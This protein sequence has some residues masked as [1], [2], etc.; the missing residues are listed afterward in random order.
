MAAFR[1]F[2]PTALAFFK[3][4]SFHQDR[5]WFHQNKSL[6]EDEVKAPM[7]ALLEDLTERFEKE[8]IPLRGDKKSV[9]RINRDIRFSKDKRPY[10]TH[11][12]AVMTPSGAKGDPGLIYIHITADGLGSWN[13]A[14]EGSFLA[15]G[16]HLPDSTVLTAFRNAIRKNPEAFQAME[17]ELKKAKLKLETSN[18]LTRVPRGFEDMK[19][20]P[21]E[22]A[23][24]LKSFIV[25]EP[26]SE[27]AVTGKKLVDTIV[28]FTQ[29]A[30]PFLDWGWRALG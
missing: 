13:D 17:A 15:A 14:P 11:T 7:L 8:G 27:A 22:G 10:Q 28:K 9:F 30:R 19:G 3:A 4:L 2:S 29:R 16:F 5:D 25:E 23:I 12:G 6:Y 18:Q 26:L 24:R 1:G 20:S 21:V